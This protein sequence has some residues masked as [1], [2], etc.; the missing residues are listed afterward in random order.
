MRGGA[1]KRETGKREAQVRGGL[2]YFVWDML[3]LYYTIAKRGGGGEGISE[4]GSKT[5]VLRRGVAR[6]MGIEP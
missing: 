5:L 1:K 2:R 6:R 3:S 4:G